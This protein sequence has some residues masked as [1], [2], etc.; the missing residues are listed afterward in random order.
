LNDLKAR[1]VW[2]ATAT[3][4]VAW[5]RKRRSVVFEGAAAK[6]G[7]SATDGLSDDNDQ[8]PE[9][10]LRIHNSPLLQGRSG[11]HGFVDVCFSQDAVLQM[12]SGNGQ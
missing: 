12:A 10:R 5:F 1:G 8:L 2:F 7:S 3:E 4:I 6:R 11:Q 9:L